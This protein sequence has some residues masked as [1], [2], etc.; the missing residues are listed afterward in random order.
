MPSPRPEA[1]QPSRASAD[2]A[3][4]PGH[5]YDLL[6]AAV[7]LI[8]AGTGR[9]LHGNPAAEELSGLPLDS[10]VGRFAVRLFPRSDISRHLDAHAEPPPEGGFLGWIRSRGRTDTA[11]AARVR[12]VPG[13]RPR[14]YLLVAFDISETRQRLDSLAERVRIDIRTG[15]LKRDE[16]E[17]ELLAAP[18]YRPG[19]NSTAALS[20]AFDGSERLRDRHG[21]EEADRLLAELARRLREATVAPALM[22]RDDGDG[23]LLLWNDLPPS[24]LDARRELDHRSEA[25]L[26]ASRRPFRLRVGSA[27]CTCSIGIALAPHDTDSPDALLHYAD[28]A[29]RQHQ[30][31]G[32]DG[33]RHFVADDLRRLT[34]EIEV[35]TGLRSAIHD[36]SLDQRWLPV[37]RL[38]DGLCIGAEVLLRGNEPLQRHETGHI[39]AIAQARGLLPELGRIGLHQ[40]AEGYAQLARSG[41]T[42]ALRYLGVNLGAD[43]LLAPGFAAELEAAARAGGLPLDRLMLEIAEPDL[44]ANM[45]RLGEV[46]GQLAEH[47]VLVAIDGFGSGFASMSA[48][49]NLPIGMIKIARR[50]VWQLEHNAYDREIVR[51]MIDLAHRLDLQVTAVGVETAAQQR[52]LRDLGCDYAQGYL[53]S[54]PLALAD[55]IE[56][57]RPHA[58]RAR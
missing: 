23:I 56:F 4:L 40:A 37:M 30:S 15:L 49:G 46:L 32:Q 5:L 9:I 45:G 50:F 8:E 18:L 10:L 36:R 12:A 3:P 21:R 16:F 54:R 1:S 33:H 42:P 14:Q 26:A 20:I 11:I 39:V 24:L 51:T 55:L 34:D 52:I 47:G 53:Y 25:L 28:L 31:Q 6:P 7:F 35:E 38:A 44:S 48:L 27:T 13:T 19:L 58:A 29:L 57:L 22:A 41:R 17:A 43:E 2:A